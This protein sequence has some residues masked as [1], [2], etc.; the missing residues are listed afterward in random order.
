VKEILT[1]Y[2]K[3]QLVSFISKVFLTGLIFNIAGTRVVAQES[4]SDFTA[5][6]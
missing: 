1:P 3:K 4:P 6:S 2:V 5:I